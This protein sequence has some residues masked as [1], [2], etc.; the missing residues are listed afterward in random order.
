ML[1]TGKEKLEHSLSWLLLYDT[2]AGK[3]WRLGCLAL[4][5]SFAVLIY[6]SESP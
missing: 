5:F 4:C 6:K 1:G 3:D 2:A